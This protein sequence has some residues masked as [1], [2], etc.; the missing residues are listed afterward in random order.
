VPSTSV[1][2]SDLIRVSTAASAVND[3]NGAPT[4][5]IDATGTV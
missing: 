2:A 3:A 5:P 4:T 1:N